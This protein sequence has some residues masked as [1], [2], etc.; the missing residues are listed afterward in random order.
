[1]GAKSIARKLNK[2]TIMDVIKHI[3][4]WESLQRS[5]ADNITRCRQ[6][7]IRLEFLSPESYQEDYHVTPEEIINYV[8]T[9]FIKGIASA[10]TKVIRAKEKARLLDTCADDTPMARS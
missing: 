1:M 4:I 10:V 9:S 3:G 6:F 7:K 8:E 2:V 5:H